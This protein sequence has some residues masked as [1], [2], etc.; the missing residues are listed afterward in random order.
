M[1]QEF[2]EGAAEA[3]CPCS[4]MSGA[5]AGKSQRLMV[6]LCWGLKSSGNA[7]T[8]R[9]G[10]PKK[11]QKRPRWS[12]ICRTHRLMAEWTKRELRTSF[13]ESTKQRAG[14]ED[15]WLNPDSKWLWHAASL[16]QNLTDELSCFLP[17]W[18]SHLFSGLLGS[19]LRF[20]QEMVWMLWK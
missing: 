18:G 11:G 9:S 16:Y 1:G 17:F 19:S 2:R 10:C 12:S 15:E 6:T 13:M 20:K 5:S 14:W 3:V 7:F 8:H 4:I